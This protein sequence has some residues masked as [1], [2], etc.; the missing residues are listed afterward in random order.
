M[1]CKLTQLFNFIEHTLSAQHFIIRP[2]YNYVRLKYEI[3]GK[4]FFVLCL[5]IYIL[6]SLSYIL[7]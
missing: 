6:K 7:K 3:M 4:H 5:T 1:F 2:D